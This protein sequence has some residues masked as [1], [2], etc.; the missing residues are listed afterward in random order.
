METRNPE[1]EKLNLT[2]IISDDLARIC[3]TSGRRPLDLYGIFRPDENLVQI[4]SLQPRDDLKKIGQLRSDR[5]ELE[6]NGISI[7]LS[8]I[9]PTPLLEEFTSRSKGVIDTDILA[10][11]KVAIVGVGSVGSMVALHLAQSAVGKFAIFD[12]DTFSASNLSRHACDLNDLGRYKTYAVRDMIHRR[13]PGAKVETHEKDFVEGYT[14]EE[15]IAAI[16]GADLVIAATDEA[17]AQFMGNEVCQELGIPSMYIGCYEL[18]C[19]GEILFVIPG[20]TPCFNCFMEFRQSF[21]QQARRKERGVPY[22]N[23][24]SELKAEPGLAIDIS[25]IVALS[26]AYALALLLPKSPRG[27]LLDPKRNL[28]LA[29]S[30]T[31]PRGSYAELFRMPF[32]LLMAAVERDKECPVCQRSPKGKGVKNG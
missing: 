32:D 15:R 26:S 19:A 27:G 8:E 20:K 11:K 25:L 7:P 4:F 24:D 10:R 6:G 14:W 2:I 29:H 30:G 31:P 13:N 23:E 3:R 1:N 22:M 12:P 9:K 18:A 17:T 21:A 28:I 5:I 16:K